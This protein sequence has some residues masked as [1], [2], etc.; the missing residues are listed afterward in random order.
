MT[1]QL[2]RWAPRLKEFRGPL[3]TYHGRQVR[4]LK[5]AMR[6]A[7]ADASLDRRVNTYSIRHTIGRH[8]RRCGVATEEIAVWMG[9]VAPPD[10]PATT[11]VYS[12][13]EP[14]YGQ[15]ARIA[16]EGLVDEIGAKAGV[17]FAEMPASLAHYMQAER[18]GRYAATRSTGAP[19]RNKR[20]G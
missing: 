1:M 19:A 5:T 3:I 7:V 8:L 14:G 20:K 18:K 10:N 6:V 15:D 17:D 11:L 2:A 4:S 13:F 12:P 9:H 16:I